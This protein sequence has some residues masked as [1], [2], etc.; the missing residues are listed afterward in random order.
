MVSVTLGL[1]LTA[2]IALTIS[3]E[4]P[5]ICEVAIAVVAPDVKLLILVRSA[6]ETLPYRSRSIHPYEM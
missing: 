6:A 3:A 4:L 5:V 2:P 1:K